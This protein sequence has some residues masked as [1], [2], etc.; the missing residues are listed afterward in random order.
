MTKKEYRKAMDCF[1]PDPF[2]KSRIAAAQAEGQ[3]AKRRPVRPLR[4]G[5]IAACL[6]LALVGT[7]FAVNAISGFAEVRTVYVERENSENM[8][9]KTVSGY[10]IDTSGRVYFPRSALSDEAQNRDSPRVGFDSWEDA[11]EYI[12]LDIA[13]NP[14]LERAV[15]GGS[16]FNGIDYYSCFANFLGFGK[17]LTIV[18]FYA[19]HY[20]APGGVE[21][22]TLP[23]GIP[24]IYA[25]PDEPLIAVVAEANVYMEDY[26][27]AWERPTTRYFANGGEVLQENYV[28]PSGLETVIFTIPCV[29]GSRAGRT[30]YEAYFTLNGAEFNLMVYDA[31]ETS[32]PE[33]AMATLKEILDAYS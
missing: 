19:I 5:L 20:F 18:E 1:E 27:K 11:E 10:T 30:D 9:V 25:D 33:F 7:G 28:T 24:G 15:H 26:D 29:S 21:L 12:G 14:V 31:S 13:D 3:G 32:D 23:D 4:A 17:E 8:D 16:S 6:C 22:H 2:M